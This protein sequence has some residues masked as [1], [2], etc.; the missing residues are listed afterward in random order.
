M[1]ATTISMVSGF[2][3]YP[4]TTKDLF[5]SDLWQLCGNVSIVTESVSHT[6]CGRPGGAEEDVFKFSDSVDFLD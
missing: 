4:A 3:L 2:H 1:M 6:M 5:K